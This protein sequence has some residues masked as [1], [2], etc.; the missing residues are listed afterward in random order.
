M[1]L[2]CGDRFARRLFGS[3]RCWWNRATQQHPH[4]LP[5]AVHPSGTAAVLPRTPRAGTHT[6]C[7]KTTARPCTAAAPRHPAPPPPPPQP[8][9]HSAPSI[10]CPRLPVG[11]EMNCPLLPSSQAGLL[12]RVRR[13]R[14]GGVRDSRL[15]AAAQ[16]SAGG[17]AAGQGV[18]VC[19]GVTF[20]IIQGSEGVGGCECVLNR[21][22]RMTACTVSICRCMNACM[23]VCVCM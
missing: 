20:M 6:P 9:F 7:P 23:C 16:P 15:A 13:P 10:S 19:R 8:P 1:L 22:V 17:W 11:S 18:C 14:R 4:A 21:R 5:Y 2:P 3:G 12:R